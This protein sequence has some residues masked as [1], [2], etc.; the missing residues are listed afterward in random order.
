MLNI[1]YEVITQPIKYL[2]LN[3]LESKYP[4]TNGSNDQFKI[5]QERIKILGVANTLNVI[6]EVAFMT[7]VVAPVVEELWFRG[8]IQFGATWITGSEK[9]GIL[10]S[11]VL[12]A[13]GHYKTTKN[14]LAFVF[15]VADC[16]FIYNPARASGGLLTSM[17]A[18][19]FHNLSRILPFFIQVYFNKNE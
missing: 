6:A 3:Y 18:H 11:T 12:F 14:P 8:A 1:A 16:Y 13:M 9:L 7:C 2:S 17:A 15:Q 10:T 4:S 19:S 5:I